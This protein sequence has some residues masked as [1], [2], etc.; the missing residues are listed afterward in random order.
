MLIE[1]EASLIKEHT[2]EYKIECLWY[3]LYPDSGAYF[4]IHTMWLSQSN[5]NSTALESEAALQTSMYDVEMN[6]TGKYVSQ[7]VKYRIILKNFM[8]YWC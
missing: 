6:W 5:V 3:T 1:R 8:E 2:A 7:H 4:A